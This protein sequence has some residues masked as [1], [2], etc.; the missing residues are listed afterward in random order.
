M[1]LPKTRAELASFIDHTLLSPSATY[2]DVD[3]LCHEAKS[4]GFHAVCVNPVNVKRCKDQLR[5]SEVKI[6]S[7]IGF[8]F[9]AN[10]TE[11]KVAEAK[12]AIED[13]ADELDMV[14]NVGAFKSGDLETVR[15]DI[16]AVAS[17]A[18]AS[19]A[20]L[21]VILE[22]GYLSDDEKV[23][24]C[25]LAVGAGADFVK[26]STGYGPGGA[27]AHDVKL[28]KEAVGGRAQVKAAGGIHTAAQALELIA[29]GASR[30]GA[31]HS[32]EILETFSAVSGSGPA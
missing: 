16:S 6:V 3:K 14:M 17:V 7:V 13:G 15:S 1:Q 27:N 9:G 5:G 22:T 10:K 26:T 21:K 12:A 20:L 11:I 29:A 18:K 4:Y 32:V 30:I 31:S 28:M 2:A 24:A 8:P 25:E 19:H 23:I